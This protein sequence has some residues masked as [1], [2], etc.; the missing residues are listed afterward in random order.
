MEAPSTD[1]RD[2]PKTWMGALWRY[3]PRLV[4]AALLVVSGLVAWR[5]AVHYTSHPP[6]VTRSAAELQI[7]VSRAT[8]AQREPVATAGAGG[9]LAASEDDSG[10]IRVYRSNGDGRGWRSTLLPSPLRCA[11]DPA[12]AAGG[13][14]A[15]VAFVAAPRCPSPVGGFPLAG[16]LVLAGSGGGGWKLATPVPGVAREPALAVDER[17]GSPHR[18][19]LYLSWVRGAGDDDRALLVS[20]SDDAGRSWSRSGRVAPAFNSPSEAS[21]AVG[22]GGRLYLAFAD[23]DFSGVWVT[24]A[25][26]AAFARPERV[27]LYASTRFIICIDR[28]KAAIV[29]QPLRCVGPRPTISVDRR[30]DVYVSY[31]ADEANRTQG[32]FAAVFSPGL[33]WIVRDPLTKAGVRIGQSDPLG[34]KSDQF[35]PV[36]ALGADGSFWACWYDTAGDWSQKQAWFTCA[37][38]RDRGRSWSR[39]FRAANRPSIEFE[40]SRAGYGDGAGLAILGDTAHPLWTDTRRVASL[41]E[42]IYATS[43]AARELR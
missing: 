23:D 5:L 3:H 1:L 7:D 22:T 17:P 4:V 39:P 27:A 38:S 13:G 29:A 41:R 14:R 30:G 43:L 42:E 33:R 11:Q 19:R 24:R 16:K 10:R 31:A 15:Y 6:A 18:G 8:G 20:H 9:L 34:R 37:V 12:V 25:E 40:T 36:S 28:G 32:V 21:L 26:G 35:L 2:P